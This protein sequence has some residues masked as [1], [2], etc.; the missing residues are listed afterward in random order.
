MN[1]KEWFILQKDVEKAILNNNHF[2][3]LVSSEKTGDN[4]YTITIRCPHCGQ[5]TSYKNFN[6]RILGVFKMSCRNCNQEM[7]MTPLAF[8]HVK[9]D[10]ARNLEVYRRIKSGEVSV[11]VTPC[12]SEAEFTAMAELALDGVKISNYMDISDAREGKPYLGKKIIKRTAENIKSLG[13][14]NFFLIPLTRYANRI[15]KHLLSLGVDQNRICRLD[16]VIIGPGDN[17]YAE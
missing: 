10:Y 8:K 15:T 2:G 7:N 5:K 12:M 6:Q 17:G 13:K 4:T 9:D 1:E 16:E 14:D 3:E 11:T